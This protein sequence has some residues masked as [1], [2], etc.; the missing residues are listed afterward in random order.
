MI[1]PGA[2]AAVARLQLVH[3]PLGHGA[4]AAAVGIDHMVG[5]FTVQRVA[6][7]HQL[8]QGLFRVAGLQQRTPTI[9]AGTPDLLLDGGMQVD[10]KAP[11]GQRACGSPAAT[12]R[13]RRWPALRYP[14]RSSP[15]PPAVH[16]HES[17]PPPPHR[18]IQGISAPVRSS[19]SVSV[20]AN[21]S[22]SCWARY[23]PMVVLPA[24]MGPTRKTLCS[25]GITA[26]QTLVEQRIGQDP[27]RD[28]DQRLGLGL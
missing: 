17:P 23:L 18:K 24:P 8:P 2:L 12:P 25:A 4:R 19:I 16:G 27:R 5:D 14:I 1:P 13:R 28:E 7:G 20:S 9:T 15:R 22:F 6:L 21:C 3:Q 11:R 10:D 26:R